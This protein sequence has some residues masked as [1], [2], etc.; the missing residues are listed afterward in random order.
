MQKTKIFLFSLITVFMLCFQ[1]TEVKASHAASGEIIY[2]WIADSTYRFFFMFYRD[3]TGI[4]E[5]TNQTLCFTNT[6]NNTTFQLTL[7]K[8]A[9]PANGSAVPVSCGISKCDNPISNV[10]GFRRWIYAKIATM[11]S[12]CNDWVISTMIADRNPNNN[13]QTSSVTFYVETHM[14]NQGAMQGNNSPY[15]SINPLPYRCVN[16]A[17]AYNAGAVDPDGDSLSTEVIMPLNSAGCNVAPVNATFVATTPAYAVPNNPLQTNNTFVCSPTTGLMTFTPTMAG[18]SVVAIRMNEYRNG[19]KIGSVIRD[20]QMQI[21]PCFGAPPPPPTFT[22]VPA[23][24][25][26]NGVVKGCPLQPVTFCFNVKSPNSGAKLKVTDDHMFAIPGSTMNYTPMY[27][28][29]I[30]GC[31]SWTPPAG[32][33]GNKTLQFAVIDS[34]CNG[35]LPTYNI[36]TVVI[37]IGKIPSITIAAAPGTTISQGT[38]VTFTATT[39]N[40]SSGSYQ[41]NVNGVA[42]SG[43]TNATWA[44][45]TIANNDVV[46]CD[47]HCNDTCASVTDTISNAITMQVTTSVAG[48][49]SF[50]TGSIYPNPNNGSFT[51]TGYVAQAGKLQL[52]VLNTVGQLVATQTLQ[53]QTGNFKHD[54]SL[55]NVLA[56][57]YILRIKAEDGTK[58]LSFTID[59]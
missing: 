17:T 35:S 13:L 40:C 22:M 46:T 37:Q 2:E 3:C 44:S 6:C 26:V 50:K 7:D 12:Q 30:M 18:S 43:A 32:T 49:N 38:P 11:P 55:V 57:V 20:M 16:Q 19:V 27:T 9:A 29:S 59:K 25:I 31:F 1:S 8:W 52:E 24:N 28:D 53:T 45:S 33:F 34:S 4:Q 41:W 10:P 48:M 15:F 5:P 36:F 47:L 14:N 51:L 39:T 23:P 21:L 56:G 54:I 42:V 58:V